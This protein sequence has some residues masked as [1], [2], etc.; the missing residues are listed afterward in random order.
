MKT[1]IQ[2]T[3]EIYGNTILK[4]KINVCDGVTEMKNISFNGYEIKFKTIKQAKKAL[5]KA[6]NDLIADIPEMKNRIGGISIVNDNEELNY[7]ASKAIMYRD[8]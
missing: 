5:R 3:G 4:N 7:D 8:F 2:I 6:Y 1:V